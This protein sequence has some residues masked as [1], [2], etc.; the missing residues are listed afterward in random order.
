MI[1]KFGNWALQR[2]KQVQFE[3]IFDVFCLFNDH[4]NVIVTLKMFV[5]NIKQTGISLTNGT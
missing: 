5:S 3:A 2:K 1:Y 4:F